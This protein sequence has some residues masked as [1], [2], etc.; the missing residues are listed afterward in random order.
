MVPARL[1][2]EVEKRA[3]F[4]LGFSVNRFCFDTSPLG[5]GGIDTVY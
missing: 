4:G 2:F 3:R 5:V 1:G